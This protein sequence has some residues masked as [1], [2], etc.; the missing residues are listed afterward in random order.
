[1]LSGSFFKP[2]EIM[3]TSLQRNYL[4]KLFEIL[5]K[6]SIVHQLFYIFSNLYL[7]NSQIL[8][9][10]L[11][12]QCNTIVWLKVSYL[13]IGLFQLILL[14]ILITPVTLY[15]HFVCFVYQIEKSY[16]TF[17]I[18][19]HSYIQGISFYQKLV[20]E[21]KY[22]NV[23]FSELNLIVWLQYSEVES[24]PPPSHMTIFGHRAFKTNQD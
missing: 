19:N 9:L 12:L 24:L 10:C 2:L 1:M 20:L 5:L 3:P 22:M 17:K 21:N 4:S 6:L 7:C 8:I 14:S 11:G 23:L 18:L 15:R 16:K 13:D